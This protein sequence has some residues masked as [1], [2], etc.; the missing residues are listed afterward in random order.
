MFQNVSIFPFL[1]SHV[2]YPKQCTYLYYIDYLEYYSFLV[3]LT[4]TV[5][6]SYTIVNKKGTRNNLPI[7][8]T[9]A[10]VRHCPNG[11]F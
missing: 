1:H 2:V 5:L 7:R 10:I 4:L 3:N 9:N 11:S 8:I 6:C